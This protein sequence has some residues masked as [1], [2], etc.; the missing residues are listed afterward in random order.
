[1]R[2]RAGDPDRPARRQAHRTGAIAVSPT[3][4]RDASSATTKAIVRAAAG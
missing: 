2:T 1:M 4:S 3:R